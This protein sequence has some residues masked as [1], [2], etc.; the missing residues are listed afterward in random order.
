[1][2]RL[3]YYCNGN[4]MKYRMSLNRSCV[5]K[6]VLPSENE[7]IYQREKVELGESTTDIALLK[8]H[9]QLWDHALYFNPMRLR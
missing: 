9:S 4:V 6:W 1:M 2:E 3:V 5:T 7:I 8:G